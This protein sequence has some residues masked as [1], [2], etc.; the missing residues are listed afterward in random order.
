MI[1]QLTGFLQLLNHNRTSRR[2]V[3]VQQRESEDHVRAR[4]Y[5]ETVVPCLVVC[6]GMCPTIEFPVVPYVRRG[7]GKLSWGYGG[8]E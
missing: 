5:T 2:L 1:T 8:R 7:G 6:S 4:T 3:K